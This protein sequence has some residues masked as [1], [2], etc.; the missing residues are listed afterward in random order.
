MKSEVLRLFQW[1]KDFNAYTHCQT[2]AQVWIRLMEL[3]SEYWQDRT[4]CE[5]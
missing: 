3:P 2:H 4:L 5:N 1:T